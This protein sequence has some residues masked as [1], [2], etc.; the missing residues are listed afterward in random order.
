MIHQER[1]AIDLGELQQERWE[2][3]SGH[4]CPECGCQDLRKPSGPVNIPGG[5]RRY[6]VCRHCGERIPLV[7]KIDPSY[8]KKKS[9]K[10]KK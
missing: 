4:A 2:A 5:Q 8:L 3:E 6:A 7:E 9:R 10:Q 1:K